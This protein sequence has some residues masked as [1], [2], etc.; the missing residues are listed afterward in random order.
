MKG[1]ILAACLAH[2]SA[3]PINYVYQVEALEI[4]HYGQCSHQI[5]VWETCDDGIRHVVFWESCCAEA[6]DGIVAQD[7]WS[8]YR[9]QNGSYIKA[10]EVDEVWSPIDREVADREWLPISKRKG[11]E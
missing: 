8:Y 4:N 6:A 11:L 1:L 7:A 10:A 3:Y 2:N 5:I 9:L